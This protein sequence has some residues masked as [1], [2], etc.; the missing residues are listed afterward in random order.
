MIRGGRNWPGIR[1]DGKVSLVALCQARK[2][3]MITK[4][5]TL[6]DKHITLIITNYQYNF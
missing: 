6:N 2:T 3:M 1:K 5:I 4:E